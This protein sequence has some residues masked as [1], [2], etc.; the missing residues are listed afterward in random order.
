MSGSFPRYVLLYFLLSAFSHAADTLE[1]ALPEL[2][3]VNQQTGTLQLENFPVAPDLYDTITLKRFNPYSA[4]ARVV[5]IE[6]GVARLIAGDDRLHYL[7][8]AETIPDV[9]IGL[10]IQ[11]QTQQASGLIIS[12]QGIYSL[13]PVSESPNYSLRLA[14][15]TTDQTP[16]LEQQCDTEGLPSAEDHTEMLFLSQAPPQLKSGNYQVVVAVDTDTEFNQERFNNNET[17]ARNWISDLF[18]QMNVMYE[19]DLG[20][21]LLQGD[22]FIRIGTDPYTQTSTSQQLDEFGTYW[23]NNMG[24]VQRVMAMLLSGKS[25]SPFSAAG[26]A[27]VDSYCETQSFG[28]SYSVNQIFTSSQVGILPNAELVGHEL[29]H[30]LGSFHTHCYNPPLDNCYNAQTGCYSGSASCPVSGSGTIMSYCHL[31]GGCD[32]TLNFHPTVANLLDNRLMAN[33]ACLQSALPTQP[34]LS[35]DDVSVNEG[36]SSTQNATL[37]V[38]LSSSSSQTVTVNYATANNT[39]TA[40]S[41]YAAKSDTLTFTPG[42]VQNSIDISIWGDT[43]VEPDE[44]LWV[45]LSNPVQASLDDNQGQIT[46]LNDDS[47][48]QSILQDDFD[49]PVPLQ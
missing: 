17:A 7:G 12:P 20:A 44:S 25:S 34:T 2:Q 21:T 28:G 32:A 27:W 3:Q 48:P 4:Q 15:Q 31:L 43:Q 37:T 30:N 36:N 39:A 19:R 29:G 35:I 18:V 40:G 14:E 42:Q 23:A 11:P 8:E 10:S 38:S 9:R 5:V 16:Q 22:T 46:I 24:S 26:I 13:N 49:D 6:N 45:N 41:D 1:V 33:S 47:N